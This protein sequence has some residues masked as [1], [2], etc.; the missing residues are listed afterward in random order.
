[1]LQIVAQ[2]PTGDPRVI[3]HLERCLNDRAVTLL[4]LPYLF[5][6]VR[7]RA[8]EALAFELEA[9]GEPRTIV[10]DDL[11]ETLN[12]DDIANLADKYL[13]ENGPW[14]AIDDPIQELIAEYEALRDMGALRICRVAFEPYART[15]SI[16]EPRVAPR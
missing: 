2:S 13:P 14:Q 9:I 12:T 10:V 11:P 4:S 5:G 3:P 15:L 16:V 8:A 6:E 7:E 1:M